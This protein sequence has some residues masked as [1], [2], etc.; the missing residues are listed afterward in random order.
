[1]NPIPPP[2][3]CAQNDVNVLEVDETATIMQ[4]PLWME[5]IR[6]VN[7]GPLRRFSYK[8]NVCNIHHHDQC[9]KCGCDFRES[10][11]ISYNNADFHSAHTWFHSTR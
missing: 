2:G 9:L 8:A 3:G 4:I 7:V 5:V 1:M 6:E 11:A 10:N